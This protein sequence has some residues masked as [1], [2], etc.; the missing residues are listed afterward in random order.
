MG[1]SKIEI[2]SGKTE[3]ETKEIDRL[4]KAKGKKT[5]VLNRKVVHDVLDITMQN[6][7]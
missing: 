3:K 4:A 7:L 5:F 2:V 1:W 6:V